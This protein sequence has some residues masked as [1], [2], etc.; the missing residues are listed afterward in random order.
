MNSLFLGI[1]I[2]LIFA[3]LF[4][5]GGVLGTVGAIMVIWAL[6]LMTDTFIGLLL[7]I[8][9][10]FTIIRIIIYILIKIIP[11]ERMRNTLI[12]SSSL[13]KDEGY[14]S[15]KDLQSYTGKV[16]IAESTLRPT[17]K[18]KIEG[19]ILDVVSEDKLIEK[20]KMV[21]VTYVDGTKVLVREMEG[22]K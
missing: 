4:V 22:E 5:P 7:A 19:R 11:K 16:G 9:V 15:S 8:L 18:A 10:S 21:K 17:G 20:G 1:G 14:I 6:T 12:L 13:N 3:E 2:A